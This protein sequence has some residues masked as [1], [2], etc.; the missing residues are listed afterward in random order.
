MRRRRKRPGARSD[1]AYMAFIRMLP[2]AAAVLG[3]CAG[4]ID[5]HH[6]GEKPGVAMKAHDRTCIPLCR[7]HHDDFHAHRGPF[8]GWTKGERRVWANLQVEACELAATPEDLG[9]GQEFEALGL[10]H[11]ECRDGRWYWVAGPGPRE[12]AA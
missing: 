7:G 3:R 5:A 4:R 12:M 10:G 8:A 1:L 6:A 11:V 2:C 9:Q